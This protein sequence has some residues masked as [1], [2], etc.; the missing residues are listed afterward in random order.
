[1]AFS[2]SG[3]AQGGISGYSSGGWAG[4]ALGAIAGGLTGS[5]KKRGPSEDDIRA[6][7]MHNTYDYF[8]N[9]MG[10]AKEN[11]VHP[12]YALGVAPQAGIQN[13]VGQDTS[14]ENASGIAHDMGQNIGRALASKMSPEERAYTE[15]TAAQALE[16]GDLENEL[17]KSQIAQIRST[18][19]PSVS[20][21]DKGMIIPGQGD[22]RVVELPSEIINGDL[23]DPR[24]QPGNMTTYQIDAAGGIAPSKDAKNSMDDDM[25]ASVLW[26]LKHRIIA[27]RNP[28]PYKFWNPILQKYQ[29]I[30]WR[31]RPNKK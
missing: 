16:R 24:R 21:N 14:S 29:D 23:T 28:D 18:T 11:G 4:A 1:M 7:N 13:Y 27:P 5:S 17:L 9:V 20:V 12:L 8:R 10:A 3:A 30:P 19:N 31:N 15:R 2:L 26:H 25:I 6:F 22:G